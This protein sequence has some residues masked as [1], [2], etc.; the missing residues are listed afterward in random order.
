MLWMDTTR[1]TCVPI[2]LLSKLVELWNSFL[3]GQCEWPDSMKLAKIVTPKKKEVTKSMMDVRP[4][5]ILSLLYRVLSKAWTKKLWQ[6]SPILL[7]GPYEVPWHIDPPRIFICLLRSNWSK[8]IFIT[9]LSWY[10]VGFDK[11]LQYPSKTFLTIIFKAFGMPASEID[12]WIS[13]T[14][15]IKK[16]VIVDGHYSEPFQSICGAPEGDPL[17]VVASALM[18]LLWF[19]YVREGR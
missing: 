14:N 9:L 18:C 19:L 4:I 6:E 17:S 8:P 15:D 7:H 10:C 3:L 2:D 5:T 1:L 16:V 12:A 11:I 13:L